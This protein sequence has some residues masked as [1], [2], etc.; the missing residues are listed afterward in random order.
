MRPWRMTC[1]QGFTVNVFPGDVP[2]VVVTVTGPVVAP[3][4]T[5]HL[6]VLFDHE[7]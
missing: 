5:V 7:A 6:M 2:M 4:G 3:T 1:S